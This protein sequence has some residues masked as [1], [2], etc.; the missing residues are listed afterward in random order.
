MAGSATDDTI[1][2]AIATASLVLKQGRRL[3]ES[4]LLLHC[5]S[6]RRTHQAW[7]VGRADCYAD[8]AGRAQRPTGGAASVMP[9]VRAII[10]D[11]GG[12]LLEFPDW[13]AQ[14]ADRWGATYDQFRAIR[15]HAAPPRAE[16][17]QAMLA[18][19]IEHWRRV[20]NEHWSGPPSGLVRDGFA[21]IGQHADEATI[22]AVLDA[23]ARA[24]DGWARP[25]PDAAPTLQRLRGK[26][27]RLGLLSN[28]WWAAEWHNA[29][30]ATHGLHHYLDELVYTSDLPHS[31]P[32][33]EVFRTVAERLGSAH[34]HCL[35]IGDR[36]VDDVSGALG[37]GMRGVLKT[38][39]R[40]P[41]VPPHITPTAVIEHLAELP[42]LIEQLNRNG[43][44]PQA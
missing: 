17:V 41:E 31:K 7:P 43:A 33:R 19:E 26:G 10:F 9:E 40:M 29:D 42:P 14:V 24:L 1:A 4:A 6:R 22:L 32:H 15:P 21:R 13:D 11:L 25:F 5:P 39:G 3:R 2:R 38:N 44:A 30:L 18:A 28:T 20:D 36:P 35:M 23:C 34:E 12:T 37:A 27:Y 16:F 8:T